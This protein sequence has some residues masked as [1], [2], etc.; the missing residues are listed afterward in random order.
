[1]D[2]VGGRGLLRLRLAR[3][4]ARGFAAEDR[5]GERDERVGRG[6]SGRAV[7]ARLAR[8]RKKVRRRNL[9][10]CAWLAHTEFFWA[11]PARCV[12]DISGRFARRSRRAA[13]GTAI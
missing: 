5:V 12:C 2:L 1:M 13:G 10:L 6:E 11:C 8:L 3:R 4:Q 9:S 7:A